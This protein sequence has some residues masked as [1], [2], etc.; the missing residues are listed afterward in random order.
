MKKSFL[1]FFI[2]VFSFLYLIQIPKV[3][4]QFTYGYWNWDSTN[5]ILTILSNSTNNEGNTEENAY[6]FQ[7]IIDSALVPSIYYNVSSSGSQFEF[8]FRL[9]IGNGT[10]EGTTWFVDTDKQVSFKDNSVTANSQKLIEVKAY[11]HFRLGF[12]DDTTKKLSSRGVSI[13]SNVSS[14]TSIYI[15]DGHLSNDIQLLSSHFKGG[16]YTH[17]IW[18]GNGGKLYNSILDRVMIMSDWGENPDTYRV[19]QYRGSHGFYYP[20]GLINDLFMFKDTVGIFFY[21]SMA[22]V[23]ANNIK[24]RQMTTYEV[25]IQAITN[26]HYLLNPDFDQWRLNWYGIS[27]GKIFRQY[28]FDL[29]IFFIN[30]SSIENANVTISNDILDVSY[31]WLTF[32]N[33]SIPQQIFTYGHYNQTGGNSIYDYNPYNITITYEGYETY[34]ALIKIAEKQSLEI[35]LCPLKA[36]YGL[37][38]GSGFILALMI[39]LA[40]IVSIVAISR[41]RS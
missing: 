35:C 7:D 11:A 37:G 25:E 38:L 41:R 29:A 27:V 2:L 40:L 34:T 16:F 32:G 28:E 13:I 31:S 6:G 20:Q 5:K 15:I 17:V 24:I 39:G 30:G 12:L 19:T 22:S 3:Y 33:G 23:T 8:V 4:A 14:Y 26:D 18:F 1:F 21:S 10:V 36:S 9:V